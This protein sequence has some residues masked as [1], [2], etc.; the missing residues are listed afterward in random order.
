M[1]KFISLVLVIAMIISTLTPATTSTADSV[2]YARLLQH[3]LYFYDANMCGG[4]VSTESAIS[5]RGNCHTQDSAIPLPAELGGGTIDL[6][7]GF[8]DAGDHIKF[9]VTASYAAMTMGLAYK[10][11]N[12]AF[13]KTGTDEHMEIILKRFADYLRKCTI[14]NADGTLRAYAYQVGDGRDHSFWGQPETK[15]N[16]GGT[17]TRIAYFITPGHPGT[18]QLMAA[19][20]AL[21]MSYY[22]FKNPEDLRHATALYNA[23]LAWDKFARGDA[24]STLS[25]FPV[26]SRDNFYQ[27]HAAKAGATGLWQDYGASAAMWLFHATGEVAYRNQADTWITAGGQDWWPLTWDNTWQIANALRGNHERLR[28]D[29]YH[30]NA[31][32]LANPTRFVWVH[33]WGS[34]VMNSGLQFSALLHDKIASQDRYGTW[35][36]GQTDYIMGANPLNR[37]FVT[38]YADNSVKHTHHSGAS[39]HSTQP[40]RNE[41]RPQMNLLIGALAG[42]PLDVNGRHEDIEDDYVGNEV[43][44][45]YNAPFIGAVAALYLQF[46]NDSMLSDTVIPSTRF[47]H[48]K[49][50]NPVVTTSPPITT[51]PPPVTT[52]P[53]VTV[54]T[55]P[56]VTAGTTPPSVTAGTT[57][58]SVTAGTTPSVTAGTTPSVTAITEPVTGTTSPVTP[59]ITTPPVTTNGTPMTSPTDGTTAVMTTIVTTATEPP[60]TTTGAPAPIPGD[61]DGNGIVTILDALEILMKLAGMESVAPDDVTINDALDILMHLAGLPSDMR[62]YGG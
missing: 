22:H 31:A 37:C 55:T 8:H 46:G 57:P 59:E 7:G 15:P 56:P 27:R 3:L 11:F 32:A 30:I 60:V 12:E 1:K 25:G 5:W 49:G 48:P 51:E 40:G 28:S 62:I 2:N 14:L 23:A 34:N 36:K 43:G 13:V 54:G 53:P 41:T 24:R 29:L 33:E 9:G 61:V 19:A 21:A 4:D 16:N 42:G 18:D 50:D 52:T 10:E 44:I 35:A 20:G 39:G 17:P 58:P 26:G 45:T 47:V 38:G 6:S